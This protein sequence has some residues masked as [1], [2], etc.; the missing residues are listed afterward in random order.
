MKILFA[1]SECAPLA[2]VGGLA[3]VAGSLPKAL[4]KQGADVN[5]ALPF[6]GVIGINK[7][8]L[9]L[10]QENIPLFFD[11]KEKYFSLWETKLPRSDVS[12]YLVE[13]K[14]YFDGDVY[15]TSDAS[16]SGTISE[17][18][19]FLFFSLAAIKIAQIIEAEII[20]ANDWHVGLI[21]KII[22]Q[23]NIPIKTLITIHN[24]GYQGIY[25]SK[26]V[27]RLLGTD[28]E[29][30]VNCLEQGILNADLINTVS[31]NYA[32]EILT[33]EF[34]FGLEKSLEQR[35]NDLSGIINGID[36][37]QFHPQND[38]FIEKKYSL[39][40]IQ[41]KK[42]NK[43]A[44]QKFCFKQAKE[45][46]PIIGLI[47]RLAEQKG[48]DLIKK[49]FPKIMSENLQ[50]VV[51]GK[52]TDEYEKFFLKEQEKYPEKLFVK[53]G[54]DEEMAHKIYAGS[55]IFL[56]PS[57]FEPCGLG[58]LIAMTY[59]TVPIVRAVGGLKD[60]VI[61]FDQKEKNITG[62]GFLFKKYEAQEM[63]KKIKQ[64]LTCFQ[65]KKIWDSLQSNGM[66]QDFTWENSAK[67]YLE[68]YKKLA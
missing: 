61:P 66:R 7:K 24:I 6:Y 15:L 1:S 14:E 19:R 38:I 11:Q 20:H 46:I 23:N 26:T 40:T 30:P 56:M 17:T 18:A 35:K 47:S 12:L 16:S 21:P 3:D 58:Q 54:F 32:Q 68:L 27:S 44:L 4:K 25:E 13:N 37:E 49:V 64:A 65:D 5:V 10:L 67:K 50:F 22:K 28:F 57:R 55:D 60:T 43:Y 39:K 59:G 63:L 8:N 36:Y 33:P 52:G 48:F 9:S 2:K 41:D 29:G 51:L 62:T 31:E 53:I 34:G 45:N 42:I